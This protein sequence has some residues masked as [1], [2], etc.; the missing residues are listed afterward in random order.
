MDDRIQ[1]E[2][3]DMAVCTDEADK[4]VLGA[5]RAGKGYLEQAMEWGKT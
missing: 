5:E 1:A 3:A 2:K 4:T